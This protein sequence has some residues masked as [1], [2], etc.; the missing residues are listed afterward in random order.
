MLP[1]F[2]SVFM[3]YKTIHWTRLDHVVICV[4]LQLWISNCACEKKILN[5]E[6]YSCGVFFDVIQFAAVWLL[7]ML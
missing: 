5:K 4:M 2:S 7:E 3:F 1:S 6:I